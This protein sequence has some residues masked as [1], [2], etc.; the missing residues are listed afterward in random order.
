MNFKKKH[1]EFLQGYIR[2]KNDLEINWNF[3]EWALP[4]CI[5]IDNL[6]MVTIL[7]VTIC[8]PNPFYNYD[9]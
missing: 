8:W 6:I 3:R 7:C 9:K 1:I 5:Y 4:L 2:F